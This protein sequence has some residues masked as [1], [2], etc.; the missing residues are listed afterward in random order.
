MKNTK[1]KKRNKL[2]YYLELPYSMKFFPEESGGY[3][4]V[5]DELEGCMS[6]GETL[7][8]AKK[9]LEDAKRLWLE[10]ALEKK[11]EIP[12]PEML[13]VYSGR[14][15][16]RVPKYLH[17]VLSHQAEREN[18]SLNQ[19]IV[20]LLSE[21]CSVKENEAAI[22]KVVKEEIQECLQAV[23]TPIKKA[24]ELYEGIKFPAVS[25]A[26]LYGFG[27]SKREITPKKWQSIVQIKE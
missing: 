17:E 20:S 9:N 3:S 18:I 14:F 8:E 22:R 24:D 23:W 1:T 6:Q 5:I 13:R 11:M 15:V 10:V 16:V 21:R 12:L 19:L 4:T 26:E 2:E 27:L 7:E 25:A